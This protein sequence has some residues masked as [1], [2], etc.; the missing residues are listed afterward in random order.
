LCFNTL[1]YCPFYCYIFN[2]GYLVFLATCQTVPDEC[3]DVQGY[4]ISTKVF[5]SKSQQQADAI[6]QCIPDSSNSDCYEIWRNI[7]CHLAF[8]NCVESTSVY[9]KHSPRQVC[10]AYCERIKE[11]THD[12]GSCPIPNDCDMSMFVHQLPADC[13]VLPEENCISAGVCVYCVY[14]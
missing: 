13:S 3:K 11:V 1:L 12:E 7:A 9:Q 6:E 14:V 8:P 10:R 4:S 2:K 5:I